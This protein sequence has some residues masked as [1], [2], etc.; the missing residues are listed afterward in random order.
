MQKITPHLWFDGNA[1]EALNFYLSVFEGS[2]RGEIQR[3]G[4]SGPMPKGTVLTAT[5][6]IF[7]QKYVLLNGGPQYKFTP[8]ISFFIDCETQ[9]EV[10]RYWEKLTE[11]G[12][13]QPCGWL[14]DKF[15]VSWQ[16]V[17]SVLP[18]LLFGPDKNKAGRVMNAMLQM[19]KIDIGA[20]EKAAAGS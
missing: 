9:A 11:G 14:V 19:K 20:L 3:Y 8:A 16:V 15:G 5:L 13:E 1:E 10:D 17:P 2:E 6:R 18:R 7:G 4:D 12:K